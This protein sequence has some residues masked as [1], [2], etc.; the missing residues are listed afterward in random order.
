MKTAIVMLLMAAFVL[1]MGTA[2]AEGKGGTLT[3]KV[4]SVMIAEGDAQDSSITVINKHGV[5]ET[6]NVLP[7]NAIYD[8]NGEATTLQNI[9]KNNRVRI[10]YYDIPGG[11]RTARTITIIR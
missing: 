6:F 4:H 7:L 9:R 11:Q 3:G 2:N 8:A 10:E 1:S 5:K